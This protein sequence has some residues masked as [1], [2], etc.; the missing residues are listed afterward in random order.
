MIILMVAATIVLPAIGIAV[1]SSVA[2]ATDSNDDTIDT[3]WLVFKSS[4]FCTTTENAAYQ[5]QDDHSKPIVLSTNNDKFLI[6]WKND[7]NEI[8]VTTTSIAENS[9]TCII[10]VGEKA[11]VVN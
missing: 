10:A 2:N 7:K 4:K 6:V 5:L 9:T 1:Y 3:R 11:M 8:T